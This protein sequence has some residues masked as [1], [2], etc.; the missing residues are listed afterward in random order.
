M[1]NFYKVHQVN[2]EICK[3]KFLDINLEWQLVIQNNMK[4]EKEEC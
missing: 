2:E 3:V 1:K 4:E